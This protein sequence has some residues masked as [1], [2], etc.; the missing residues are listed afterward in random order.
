MKSTVPS[1]DHPAKPPRRTRRVSLPREEQARL[2][3][4]CDLALASE[5]RIALR[6]LQLLYQD[7]A[8]ARAP[9][10]SEGA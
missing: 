4:L 1:R 6:L 3:E 2:E 7:P 8:G 9:R 10:V 5:R